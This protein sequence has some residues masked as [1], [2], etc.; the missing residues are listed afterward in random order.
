[1]FEIGIKRFKVV[2][3]RNDDSCR[4]TELE[5]EEFGEATIVAPRAPVLPFGL[6]EETLH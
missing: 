3:V 1:M 4:F 6:E 2:G 5:V